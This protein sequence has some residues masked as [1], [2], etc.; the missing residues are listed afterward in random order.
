MRPTTSFSKARMKNPLLLAGGTLAFL[1]TAIVLQPA[2][3]AAVQTAQGAT[4]SGIVTR[5]GTSEPIPDVNVLVTNSRIGP[6]GQVQAQSLE[7]Q[8]NAAIAQG[9]AIPPTIQAQLEAERARGS[10]SNIQLAT[11]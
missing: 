9:R 8:V 10:V 6:R 7:Q 3:V 4:I 1:A 5:I 11:K 2:P